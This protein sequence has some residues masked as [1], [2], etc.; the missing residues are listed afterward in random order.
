MSLIIAN[1]PTLAPI[2]EKVRNGER[3][4]LEDGLKLYESPDLL[5][6]GQLANEVNQKKNGD[7]VYF[8]Q[9][10]YIN[11]T[12]VC[13]AHCKFCGF[14][15]DP[16]EEGAY[17]MG[18]EDLLR[19]VEERFNPNIR[20]FHITGGH[21]HT[22][23][24]DYYVDI[25]KT[26]KKHYP[27]VTI[28]AYTA[29]EIVF[30]SEK[31][32][33]SIEEILNI[34]ID[35]GLQ[36]MP[37]GGAEILSER[38]R[39]L[40]SPEKATTQQWLDVHEAAHRLGLKTHATMLYGS[41]ETLEERL[42]HMIHVRELQDKTNGF[43]VFIPLA[44]QPKKATA[45]IKMRTSAFDDLKTIAISRLML[46]NV[47][48]IKAYFINIGTQLT[49]L[50]LTFGASDVHGTLVEERISHAAGALTQVGLTRDEL[51]WLI[52]GANKIPVERDTFYNKIKIYE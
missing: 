3:L 43:Y 18:M 16:G 7:Y 1:D 15:R 26:L 8:T 6:I 14:R 30:F 17:T 31:T 48:H 29:A 27:D 21:N 47:D 25:V 44:V 19:Y 22:V 28:K 49:Q 39:L 51:V 45:S 33:K 23:G 52:K 32:G 41:I 13:E 35:A 11:P 38:Y 46:D 34:L 9:N 36:T 42:M 40:M 12:N 10:M 37:G 24:F 20:E 5:T 50:A 2:V 4:T